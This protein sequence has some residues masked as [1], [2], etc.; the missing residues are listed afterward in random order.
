MLTPSAKLADMARQV[1]MLYDMVERCAHQF[2]QG[3]PDMNMGGQCAL[4]K[5]NAS[6]VLGAF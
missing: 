6:R 1:E 4:L 2:K 5:V 3:V